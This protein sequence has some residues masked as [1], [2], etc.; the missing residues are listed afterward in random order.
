M[1]TVI[2]TTIFI[3]SYVALCVDWKL[4]VFWLGGLGIT[5]LLFGLTTFGR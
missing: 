1:Y 5:I 4:S 2:I 3:L